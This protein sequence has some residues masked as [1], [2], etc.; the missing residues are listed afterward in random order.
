MIPLALSYTDLSTGESKVT[1]MSSFEE[2]MNEF[3][4]LG[5]SE[6]VLASDFNEEWKKK[7]QERGAKAISV[8]DSLEKSES[9][10]VLLHLLE[11]RK[12]SHYYNTFITVLIPNSKTFA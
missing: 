10:T 4:I 6:V 9:F 12:T 11:S 8:E 1:L 7:L 5:A 3:A 2:V